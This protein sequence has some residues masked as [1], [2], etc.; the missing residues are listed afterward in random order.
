MVESAGQVNKNYSRK[1]KVY[2]EKLGEV[3]AEKLKKV[4]KEKIVFDRNARPYSKAKKVKGK[5]IQKEKAKGKIAIF[6]ETMRQ[7]GINF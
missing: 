4:G 6:C 3:F 2:A 1:N 5:T 7:L